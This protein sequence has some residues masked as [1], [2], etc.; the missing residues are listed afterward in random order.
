MALEGVDYVSGPTPAE[1]RRAGKRFVCRYVSTPGNPKNLT[2]PEVRELH[3]NGLAVVVVFETTARRALDGR[4]AG[5]ADATSARAQARALGWRRPR[6]Y[7]A[8]DFDTS[9]L[10]DGGLSLV[11]DYVRGAA[12]VLGRR[13]TGVYGGLRTVTACQAAGVC[14]YSWQTYAW[15]R[16]LWHPG[17]NLEQYENGVVLAGHEVDLDRAVRLRFGSWRPWP[18]GF[19]RLRG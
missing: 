17:V 18:L 2:R 19:W 10:P 6:I 9:A 16:G 7:F 1:L 15:S 11:V 4:A 8:V 3:A 12:D 14:R 5:R 13:R